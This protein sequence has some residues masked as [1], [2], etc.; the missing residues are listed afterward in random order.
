MAFYNFANYERDFHEPGYRSPLYFFGDGEDD[1]IYAVINS[2]GDKNE[3]HQLDLKRR[4]QAIANRR[5]ANKRSQRRV[6]E[7][8][9]ERLFEG[10]S[11]LPTAATTSEKWFAPRFDVR[12]TQDSYYLHGELPGVEQ[13]DVDIEFTDPQ[14]LQVRGFVNRAHD[15]YSSVGDDT[16]SNSSSSSG[17]EHESD[18]SDESSNE[19]SGDEEMRAFVSAFQS[20]TDLDAND[21]D[22]SDSPH[23]SHQASVEDVDEQGNI[24]SIRRASR[25]ASATRTALE[26][27][28]SA[29]DKD[30][31]KL[32]W[33]YWL[34]ERSVGTFQRTFQFPREVD[35]DN[36]RAS[37]EQGIL[38][39]KVP[40]EVK[41][42]TRRIAIE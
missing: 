20:D 21:S 4:R 41:R 38:T 39:V 16:S 10:Y 6:V 18:E 15:A 31:D 11:D 1:H 26:K 30:K 22:T 35:Q 2:V 17:E 34:T 37:L 5:K 23:I 29:K 13:K 36:V 28:G 14:T 27:N 24:I 32:L 40:K 9:Q 8:P 25:P 3:R 33:R 19:S 12:E 42:R 7:R